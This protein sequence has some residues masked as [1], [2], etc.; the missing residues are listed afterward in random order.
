MLTGLLIKQMLVDAER[1]P[2][3]RKVLRHS[4]GV[5]LYSTP[6]RG[7]PLAA[8]STQA[9]FILNPSVEVKELSHSKI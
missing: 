2:Q 7:T 4:R 3:F 6:H 1:T 9:K 5:V 8:Y